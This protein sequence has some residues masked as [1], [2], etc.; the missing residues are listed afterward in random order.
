MVRDD[1]GKVYT[2]QYE[3]VNATLLNEFHKKHRALQAQQKEIEPLRAELK[4]AK[5]ADSKG[6]R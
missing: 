1:K 6:Q 5:G 3:E 2:V 4:E